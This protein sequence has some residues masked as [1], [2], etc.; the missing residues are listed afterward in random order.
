MALTPETEAQILRHHHAERWPIGTIATQLNI[1][2]DSVARVLAQAGLP[3]LGT[4]HRPSTIDPYLPF[5]LETLTQYPRLRAS[6]LYDMAKDR[7]Y[8]GRP[9]HFRHLIARHRPRPKSEAYLRLRTLPGEQMQIDWGHFGHLDIGRAHRPLMGFVAV[10]SWSRQIFLRFYLGAHMENFLRGHVGAMT[11]WGGCPRVALYDNLK[12]AVLERHGN[13]IRFHPTLLALS[14]HYHF[15]PRPVAVARGN[16]KGRVERAIRYIRDA[17]FAGRTFTDIDDLN[18]QADDWVFGRAGERRCPEDETLTVRD[19]FAQE[20][21]RLLALPGNPFP[22]DEIKAVSAGKTP[23]VRFDLN[24]YSIP[25]TCVARTLTVAANPK[26]VRILDGQ[27]VLAAHPRSYD[28]RQQ[29]E[30]PEH[31]ATLVDHKHQAGAHR[32]TDHLIKAVPVSRELLTQ[33][34][35]RGEPLGRTVRAL[36]EMLA[37]YGVAELEAA[38]TEALARQVPHPNAVRLALERRRQANE[39]PPPIAITLPDHVKLRDVPVRP[40]KLNSYDH[41]METDDDEC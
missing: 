30:L 9:D 31:I 26:E 12:S 1:H 39:A 7:G 21:E 27:T 17:F 14:G 18:A 40:H 8:P 36:T 5:I 41:L 16:E 11:A 2:R 13:V 24:D 25:H 4:V 19:A 38:I 37:T 20:K 33:A 35:E 22:T 6:R 32:G 15:D 34:T 3:T 28:R 23:Y 29:I 10:L